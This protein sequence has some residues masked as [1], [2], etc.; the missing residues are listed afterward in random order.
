[1]NFHRNSLV[2]NPSQRYSNILLIGGAPYRLLLLSGSWL[3]LFTSRTHTAKA[4]KFISYSYTHYIERTLLCY[5]Q[6]SIVNEL[7]DLSFDSDISRHEPLHC[8]YRDRFLK[9]GS[10]EFIARPARYFLCVVCLTA[11]RLI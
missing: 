2:V 6:Y 3:I 5:V 9:I 4:L 10:I 8:I 7:K 11:R 1:M